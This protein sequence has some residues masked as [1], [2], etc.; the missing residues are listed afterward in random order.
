MK[1]NGKMRKLLALLIVVA[2]LTGAF[3][4]GCGGGDEPAAT[5][6]E[7]Y[8]LRLGTISSTDYFLTISAQRYADAVYEATDGHVEITVY[9]SNQLGDYTQVFE[10]MMLGSIDL[11]WINISSNFDPIFELYYVPGLINNWEQAK[12]YLLDDDTWLS[13]TL[14]ETCT[15]LGVTHLG[16]LACGFIGIGAAK[17]D[18]LPTML[19]PT[20]KKSILVRCPDL[21]IHNET[22]GSMGFNTVTVSFADLYSALE[23]GVCDAT[24]G[25]PFASLY[26]NFRDVINYAI[27]YRF[28][29]ESYAAVMSN[30]T[31]EKLPAEYQQ[32]MKD[33]A[34]EECVREFDDCQAANEAAA[35]QLLDYGVEPIYPTQEELDILTDYIRENVWPVLSDYI[36][37]E[38]MDALLADVEAHE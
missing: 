24:Y 32:I 19:D 1:V 27:D 33:L 22:L 9:P 28:Y 34:K 37:K 30:A 36:G 10:E 17:M 15:K 20:V 21:L 25:S 6:D 16:N 26:T 2:L 3:L 5:G 29:F 23:S 4:T 8:K 13:K 12:S 14:Q 7:V 38:N 18:P 31:L 11:G 35:Q